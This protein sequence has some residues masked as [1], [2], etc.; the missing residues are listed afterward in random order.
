M[1][2]RMGSAQRYVGQ[3]VWLLLEMAPLRARCR[4][5][6]AAPTAVS[7]LARGLLVGGAVPTLVCPPAA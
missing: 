7:G 6:A 2:P 5:E 4:V 1:L 3:Q